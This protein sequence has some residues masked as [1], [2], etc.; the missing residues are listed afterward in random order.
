MCPCTH[1]IPGNVQLEFSLPTG[2]SHPSTKWL[3]IEC[4]CGGERCLEAF[5]DAVQPLPGVQ[6]FE[7]KPKPTLWEQSISIFQDKV[8][9]KTSPTL[10]YRER[11]GKGMC[12]PMRNRSY[13][14][15]L[16]EQGPGAGP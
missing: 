8:G 3:S 14:T 9:T 11:A 16:P 12:A 13:L 5:R 2:Q 7:G 1:K 10:G 6:G 4:V 15:R